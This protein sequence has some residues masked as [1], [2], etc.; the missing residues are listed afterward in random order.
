MMNNHIN[1]ND[2][3]YLEAGMKFW[4]IFGISTLV[5]CIFWLWV[6]DLV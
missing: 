1:E 4:V 3:T 5:S 6:F 2:G